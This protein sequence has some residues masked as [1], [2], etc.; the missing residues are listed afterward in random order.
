MIPICSIKKQQQINGNGTIDM[1]LNHSLDFRLLKILAKRWNFSYQFI[2]SQQD[3]GTFENNIWTGSIGLIKNKTV[4][5]G[6]CGISH[7][8]SRSLIVDFSFITFIDSIG[9]LTKFPEKLS[10][11]W[12]LFQSFPLQNWITILLSYIFV[13]IFLYLIDCKIY[14]WLRMN[15]YQ[16]SRSKKKKKNLSISLKLTA[17]YL[18]RG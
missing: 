15:R 16:S 10:R 4:D 5:M 13:W 12:L 17:I 8:Y 3:W 18:N 6:M 7:T 1:D 2:D 11:K 14:P 9:F